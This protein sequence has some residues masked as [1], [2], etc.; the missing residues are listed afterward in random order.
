M[1]QSETEKLKKEKKKTKKKGDN[2]TTDA[3]RYNQDSIQ[4]IDMKFYR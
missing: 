4:S 1:P 2:P 3:K